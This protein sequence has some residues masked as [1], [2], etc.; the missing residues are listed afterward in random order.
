[1]NLGTSVSI[2]RLLDAAAETAAQVILISTIV[3]HADVHKKHMQRLDVLARERGVRDRLVLAAGGAQVT[4]ELARACG[5]D[6]GFGR[7]AGGRDVASFL[8]R[9]LRARETP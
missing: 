7:G 8:V 9:T 5:L 4:D 3:S 6:A 1:L 2:E